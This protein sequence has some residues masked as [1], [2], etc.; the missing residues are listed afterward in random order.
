MHSLQKKMF[1]VLT[2]SVRLTA[3]QIIHNSV[4]KLN[5]VVKIHC[6]G[7]SIRIFSEGKIKHIY[8]TAR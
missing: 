2:Q 3:R 7:K 8:N 5:A 6:C 4:T 1:A